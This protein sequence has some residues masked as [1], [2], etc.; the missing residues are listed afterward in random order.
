MEQIFEEYGVSVVLFL[1]GAAVIAGLM[2]V[3]FYL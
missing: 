1:V 2:G 3:F